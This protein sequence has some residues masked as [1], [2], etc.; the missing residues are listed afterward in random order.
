[1]REK[2]IRNRGWTTRLSSFHHTLSEKR[3]DLE[4]TTLPL[5]EMAALPLQL[6]RLLLNLGAVYYQDYKKVKSALEWSAEEIKEYLGTYFPRSFIENSYILKYLTDKEIYQN[7]LKNKKEL[8]ILD[9]GSGTGGNLLSLLFFLEKHYKSI[10]EIYIVSID[11]NPEALEI[12][13]NLI[14]SFF[15]H[16]TALELKHIFFENRKDFEAK[17]RWFIPQ[18]FDS[19]DIIMSSKFI[20]EFYR[21]DYQKN[22]GMYQTFLEITKDLITE[23]GIILLSD[24]TDYINYKKRTYYFNLLMNQEVADFYRSGDDKVKPIFPSGC[25]FWIDKCQDADNCF[26]QVA[27]DVDI[28]LPMINSGY[29]STKRV[30]TKISYKVFATKQFADKIY[31]GVPE[32]SCEIN[33]N[34]RS[35]R[36]CY[37]GK[38]YDKC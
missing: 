30:K 29:I 10:E 27:L 6:N 15:S 1:M 37:Q 36:L 23:D 35:N 8:Y 22:S 12:Q 5:Q 2:G 38:L 9:I 34:R 4:V 14:E 31:E 24:I 32:E 11:G 16:K 33:K 13:Q 25:Y 18:S 28:A 3:G 26:T 19:Y 20:N 17:M 7:V 21:K